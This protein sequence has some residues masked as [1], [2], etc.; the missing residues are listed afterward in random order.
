MSGCFPS[1]T[2]ICS[3]NATEQFVKERTEKTNEF[4][5]DIY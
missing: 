5:P 2:S 4:D 3:L 1:L